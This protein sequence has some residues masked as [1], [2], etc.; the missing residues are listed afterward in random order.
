M[1]HGAKKPAPA[2]VLKERKKS[3]SV[4]ALRAQY[5]NRS[6]APTCM[7]SDWYQLLAKLGLRSGDLEALKELVRDL[8]LPEP[9][10]KKVQ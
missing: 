2:D 8:G 7:C 1:S 3:I 10:R 9:R 5:S 6:G 4:S